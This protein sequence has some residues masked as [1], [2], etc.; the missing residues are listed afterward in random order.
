MLRN[1][2]NL[3]YKFSTKKMPLEYKLLEWRLIINRELY[4]EK[5]IELDVFSEMEKSILGRLTKIRNDYNN[6]IAEDC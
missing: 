6:R 5:V 2:E 3:E 4:E 1:E